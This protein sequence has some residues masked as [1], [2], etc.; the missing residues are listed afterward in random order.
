MNFT[1][2]NKQN[3]NYI[4][5]QSIRSLIIQAYK[6]NRDCIKIEDKVI[7]ITSSQ[8][9]NEILLEIEVIN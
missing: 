5:E 6:D 1:I 4:V 8:N 3:D 9:E 7:K 2:K